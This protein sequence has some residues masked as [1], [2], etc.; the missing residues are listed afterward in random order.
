MKR[1]FVSIQV[2]FYIMMA[3]IFVG[4][5]IFGI[6]RI[7]DLGGNI[8]DQEELE[9]KRDIQEVF[10]FC[11]DPLNDYSKKT[12]EFS[13]NAF[14]IVCVIGTDIKNMPAPSCSNNPYCNSINNLPEAEKIDIS[15]VASTYSQEETPVIL[16]KGLYE[17]RDATFAQ[18]EA[19]LASAEGTVFSLIGARVVADMSIRLRDTQE[20]TVCWYSADSNFEKV[21]ISVLC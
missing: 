13:H 12:L 4:I 5:L 10:E 19:G 14:D 16:L 9:I 7:A 18:I 1:A 6:G 8:S 3:F 2:I 15:T 20:N 21:R 17:E 11:E